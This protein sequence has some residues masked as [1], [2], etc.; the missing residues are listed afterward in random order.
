[1]PLNCFPISCDVFTSPPSLAKTGLLAQ[2]SLW[3][4]SRWKY[5]RA[6]HHDSWSFMPRSARLTCY[7][8]IANVSPK[9]QFIHQFIHYF[10][11]E[12][13][14]K[15]FKESEFQ[16]RSHTFRTLLLKMRSRFNRRVRK[17]LILEFIRELLDEVDLLRDLFF[18]PIGKR[19]VCLAKP[20]LH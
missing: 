3:R 12:T 7:W 10:K 16:T 15:I 20:R 13:N 8:R 4:F 6:L 17:R 2:K 9:N 11:I 5:R 18:D 19:P 14:R 1:M